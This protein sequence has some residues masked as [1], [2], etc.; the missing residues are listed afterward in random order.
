MKLL[1]TAL[2]LFTSVCVNAQFF[3]SDSQKSKF[4]RQWYASDFNVYPSSCMDSWQGIQRAIDSS[5]KLKGK[6]LF[7]FDNGWSK[8]KPYNAE[9]AIQMQMHQQSLDTST[10]TYCLVNTL[11]FRTD[12]KGN[13]SM[14]FD[15]ENFLGISVYSPESG[16]PPCNQKKE[17][18]EKAF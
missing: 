10:W 14:W 12:K 7:I 4:T 16:C 5:A 13:S 17:P 18:P 2:I 9:V 1:L 6:T 11:H 8:M 3:V 15:Y